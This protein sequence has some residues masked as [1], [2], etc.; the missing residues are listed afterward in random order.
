MGKLTCRIYPSVSTV[1][2][3]TV[4]VTGYDKIL[5]GSIVRIRLANLKTLSVG[6]TDFVKIGVSL[7]YYAYGGTKGYIYEPV[8]IVVGPPTASINPYAITA[9]VVESS[10][11]FVGELSNYTFTGT[12]ANGFSPITTSDFIAV[13]FPS[14]IFEGRFNQNAQAL[15]SLATSS[16]CYAFG[17][18]NIIYIQPSVTI[19]SSALSFTIK[20]L[21]NAAFEIVYKNQ[22][23]KIFTVVNNKI[24]ALGSAT[25][26]KFTKASLNASA[27]FISIGSIYGGDS[28]INYNI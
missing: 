8:S 6:V 28:G 9:S 21:L 17:L 13:Q 5:A 16:K 2:Y 14:Y 12:I 11:N 23:I 19:S 20:K 25:Y 10:S 4:I 1:T 24:N 27:I 26:L 18:A 22:T 3:P 7:T 15:C